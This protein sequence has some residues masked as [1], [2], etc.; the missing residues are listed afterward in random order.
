MQI[1]SGHQ[2][3]KSMS[4]MHNQKTTEGRSKKCWQYSNTNSETRSCCRQQSPVN[5]A[6][7][8]HSAKIAYLRKNQGFPNTCRV[9]QNRPKRSNL[10]DH[11]KRWKTCPSRDTY[12]CHDDVQPSFS[13]E[14][15]CPLPEDPPVNRRVS[16]PKYMLWCVTFG[17]LHIA[18]RD[19]LETIPHFN[20]VK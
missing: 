13:D 6:D 4:K 8:K 20:S 1:C 17:D 5:N 19:V 9:V 3:K 14:C 2:S 11:K 18:W 7:Q 16:S 15:S 12:E 10:G